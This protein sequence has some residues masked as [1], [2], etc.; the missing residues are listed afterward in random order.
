MCL[1]WSSN[2][3]ILECISVK[4]RPQ[5]ISTRSRAV[6]FHFRNAD[7][8]G[9]TLKPCEKHWPS[10]DVKHRDNYNGTRPKPR[11][12]PSVGQQMSL[13][14][15][16]TDWDTDWGTWDRTVKN[17]RT[18]WR[19]VKIRPLTVLQYRVKGESGSVFLNALHWG[20]YL[21]GAGMKVEEF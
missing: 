13:V 20:R 19:A 1:F 21:S 12:A 4:S 5:T 15:P 16:I 11:T 8:H 6:R 18:L 3:D 10:I 2:G 17:N 14:F 7:G 9:E